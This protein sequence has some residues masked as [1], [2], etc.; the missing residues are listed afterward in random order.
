[1]RYI[2]IP[3]FIIGFLFMAT[4][5]KNRTLSKRAWIVG[6]LALGTALC[7]V[8]YQFGAKANMALT[9]SVYLYFLVHEL[10]DET[11]FYNALGDAPPIPDRKAFQQMTWAMMYLLIFA[12]A[13][14]GW[15]A[16][17]LNLANK[18][19]QI[20]WF[21]DMA[22]P[23]RVL[24]AFAPLAVALISII[25]AT[26]YYT[27]RLGYATPKAMFRAHAPLFRVSVGA[28]AV[29]G[30]GLLVV[31]RPYPLILLHVTAWYVFACHQL[32]RYPPKA[33]AT[34]WWAWMRTDV[35]GFKVLHIG[36]AV[37]L[38]GIGL[39]WTLALGQTAALQWLLAPESFMYWTIM[40]ITVSFVPR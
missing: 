14:I 28:I 13:A 11:M 34:G 22:L 24:I 21:T 23:L 37:V 6:L 2:T 15:I 38:M 12:T 27:A 18:A 36:L 20:T 10:R 3:H 25:L 19:A 39:V 7:G 31:Q 17:P 32:R 30:L 9:A 29:L 35:K 16:F 4:S 33:P 1:M 5:P 26:G 40:H 8:Y